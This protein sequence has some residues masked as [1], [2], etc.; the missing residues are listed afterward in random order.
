MYRQRTPA[1]TARG[2][3][4][5]HG[6]EQGPDPREMREA[7]AT[8]AS[9]ELV[10]TR[11]FLCDQLVDP[12][13]F[14]LRPG[15]VDRADGWS[16][17]PS[18]PGNPPGYDGDQLGMKHGIASPGLIL[19]SKLRIRGFGKSALQRQ[20]VIVASEAHPE[21]CPKS[22]RRYCV[23]DNYRYYDQNHTNIFINPSLPG[24]EGMHLFTWAIASRRAV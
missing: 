22:S 8:A 15:N 4:A 24:V 18:R 13:R 23:L 21:R 5:R 9:V 20:S 12:E 7:G 17:S 16:S 2:H 1:A 3:R 6:C 10:I 19:G 14:A 11:S